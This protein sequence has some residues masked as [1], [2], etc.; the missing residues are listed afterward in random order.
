MP[1]AEPAAFGDVQFGA[2]GVGDVQF[3]V[4]GGVVQAG[5]VV[6]G[7]RRIRIGANDRQI[8]DDPLIRFGM[9]LD[10]FDQE[11]LVRIMETAVLPVPLISS[12]ETPD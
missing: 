4:G 7:R 6:Q 11:P 5:V 8:V 2:V 12:R 3:P 9:G 1:D 10:G